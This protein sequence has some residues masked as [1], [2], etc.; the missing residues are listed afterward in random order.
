M[1]ASIIALLDHEDDGVRMNAASILGFMD[2]DAVIPLIR[3]LRADSSEDVRG[4]AAASLG[5]LGDGRAYEPLLAALGDTAP[6]VRYQAA[7][8]LGEIGNEQTIAV[9]EQLQQSDTQV[10]SEP[11][12]N[13]SVS[14]AA[15]LS[16]QKI[17]KRLGEG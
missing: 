15:Q 2:T 8:A 4:N 14:Q 13:I 12:F 9:L 6:E 11:Q 7:M 16:I 5:N 10:F 1:A 17:K 3:A